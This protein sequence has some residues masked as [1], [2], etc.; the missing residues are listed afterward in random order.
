MLSRLK[1]KDGISLVFSAICILV[2]I[3]VVALVVDIGRLYLAKQRAQNVADAS[4]LAGAWKLDGTTACEGEATTEAQSV[5]LVNNN[6]TVNWK[7]QP[8]NGGDP[9]TVSFPTT[10]QLADGTSATVNEGEAIKVDCRVPVNFIFAPVMGF[11]N[12][13]PSAGSIVIRRSTEQ[14]TYN[15]VP[16]CVADTTIWSSSGGE[17]TQIL[18]VG[19]RTTLK[20]TNPND[21]AS[22][23]GPGNFLAVAYNGE[24]GGNKYRDRIAG[25]GAPITIDVGKTLSELNIT[26]EPG[27]KI[28]PTGQG[29]D[30]RIGND[31][32]TFDSWK[33]Q[34]E[35]TGTYPQTPRIVVV[36][37]IEDP[38]NPLGGRKPLQ[39]VGFAG[40]FLEGFDKKSGGVTGRFISAVDLN[41][42]L[43]WGLDVF[44]GSE[45]T[46]VTDIRLVK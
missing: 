42:V 11:E 40:Y 9:V 43:K 18:D 27:N 21:P 30:D 36:P 45:T 44:G 14:L 34:G 31:T 33:A 41:G 8:T 19:A 12:G 20:I 24:R 23:I 10:V 17:F 5:A 4:S 32:W 2:L 28:G 7:V 1:K 15:L 26:T 29:M 38:I 16:W 6:K 46:L 3:G 35:S 13:H 37:I 22:F 25:R 39:I